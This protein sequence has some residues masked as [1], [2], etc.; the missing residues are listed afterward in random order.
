MNLR[1]LLRMALINIK[2]SKMRSLLTTLGIMIGIAAVIAVVAIGEGGRSA[3]NTEVEKF[4]TNIFVVYVRDGLRAGDF[5]MTDVQVI[6][7]AVPQVK[8]LAPANSISPKVRGPRK[9]ISLNIT[10]TTSEMAAI[11]N[12]EMKSGRFIN[13]A[14]QVNSRNVIVLEEDAAMELFGSAD[15]L[16]QQVSIEGDG[17]LVVGVVKKTESKLDGGGG[18][19]SAYVPLSF[20]S[21][22]RGIE[23]IFYMYGSAVSKTTV[24]EAMNSTIKVLER[25]HQSPKHYSGESMQGELRQVNDILD[26]TGIIISSIAGISLLVGGIGVMNIMLVSVSDRTREIGI[27]MA[28]GA[29]R[30]DILIQFLVEA[31]VLCLIGGL[32]GTIIGYSGAF[33]VAKIADWPPLVSWGT[34]GLAFG[35]STAVGLIFGVYPANRAARLDPIEA[36]RRD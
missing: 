7:S 8:Y 25:R 11:R 34:I 2:G 17:A 22:M 30:R 9:E 24:D 20:V 14:D 4:G 18:N 26:I 32:L 12:I 15:P 16:G 1:E 36:L 27:R 33:A 3:L 29:R 19:K 10:G 31:I 35:F 6:K 21:H 13:E 5:Q 28:L 23:M